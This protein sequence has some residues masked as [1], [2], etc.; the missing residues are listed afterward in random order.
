M[1]TKFKQDRD[2]QGL[3]CV[4]LDA[5][6]ESPGKIWEQIRAV[7]FLAERRML[8]LENTLLNKDKTFLEELQTKIADNTLPESNV[9]IFWEATDKYKTKLGKSLMAQLA[10]EKFAQHFEPLN[11]AQLIGWI[12]KEV[13]DRNGNIDNNAAQFIANNL[14]TDM[15]H[16][17]SLLDQLIAYKNGDQIISSDVEIFLEK[18]VDDNIFNLV[19]A[20]VGKQPKK[21]FAMIEKQYNSGK[22]PLYIFA[23]ILRQFRI[24]LELKDLE[25]RNIAP[26][27]VAKDMGLHPFVV[28]KTTPLVAKYSQ[29]ELKN[30]YQKLL[31]I[32]MKTKT[33]KADPRAMVDIFVGELSLST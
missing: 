22:D 9:I 28:K 16:I 12:K 7:P 32:D 23:M 20:I 19:D 17:H 8:V 2:P 4:R 10:K 30:I 13:T 33:G 15:W 14:G 26:G 11:S 5:E 31:D 18:K 29:A 1:T 6:K 3:N 27:S 21:V 25:A 24:M